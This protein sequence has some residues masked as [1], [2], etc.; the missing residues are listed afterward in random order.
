MEPA[1]TRKFCVSDDLIWGF[2]RSV[3]VFRDD[4]LETLAERCKGV[5]LS[6][7]KSENML[8]ICERLEDRV[9]HIHSSDGIYEIFDSL[10]EFEPFYLCDHCC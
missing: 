9:Y 3:Q 8:V 4:T 7:F 2:S 5:I 6:F 10:T 1:V